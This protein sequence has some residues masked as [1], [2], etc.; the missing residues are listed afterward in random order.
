MIYFWMA[1]GEAAPDLLKNT[2][3]Q[4]LTDFRNG[5]DFMQSMGLETGE[6]YHET[7]RK[8][9]AMDRDLTIRANLMPII[10]DLSKAGLP[11]SKPSN[12]TKLKGNIDVKCIRI[13]LDARRVRYDLTDLEIQSMSAFEIAGLIYN[14]SEANIRKLYE[15]EKIWKVDSPQIIDELR[16]SAKL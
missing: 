4:A 11:K 13:I 1:S 2:Y 14:M 15:A 9:Q 7:P 5:G 10:D 12:A 6:K 16:R 3:D 8:R